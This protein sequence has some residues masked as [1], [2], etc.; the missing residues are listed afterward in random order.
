[1]RVMDERRT[2]TCM[3]NFSDTDLESLLEPL[4]VIDEL[5]LAFGKQFERVRM[6]ARL[7]MQVGSAVILVMPCAIE[8]EPYCGLKTV[9]V[10]RAK[11]GR[12]VEASYMLMDANDGHTIAVLS[13]NHLTDLRTAAISAIATELLATPAAATLGIFGT[14]RQALAHA[15]LL[16]RV[17]QFD[18]I[19]VCGSSPQKAK[20]FADQVRGEPADAA[21]C[22]RESNVICTCTTATTPLFPGELIRPGTHLNLIGAFQPHAREVDSALI[23]RARL[24]VDTYEGAFAEAGDILVPLAAGEIQ[25]DHVRGDLH[26]L[27]T[28]AKTGRTNA[29]DITVF[30]SLGCA[31]EDLVTARLAVRAAQRAS[32]QSTTVSS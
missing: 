6:P 17:R 28:G 29:S 3:L 2:R 11:S 4:E 31:L 23:R 7:Q 32:G 20:A 19:L 27:V 18:R 10:S 5:R 9:H 26:E 8:G 22:A 16:P 25:R 14:G 12:T 15:A 24:F 30:K 13:A 21:T 1:M